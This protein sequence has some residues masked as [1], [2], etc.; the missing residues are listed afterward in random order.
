MK[1]TSSLF[2]S[3]RV[4]NRTSKKRPDEP[5]KQPCQWEGC[6]KAGTHKAPM[7]RN[8]EGQYLWMCIDHVRDY[9]KNFN[10]F[11][12]LDDD[13]IAKFQKDAITGARP[14]W[15]MGTN[16]TSRHPP[17]NERDAN[18]EGA[19]RLYNRTNYAAAARAGRV[20]PSRARKLKVLEKKSF[21]DLNLPY[22]ATSEELKAR[23]KLLVKQNHPD[24]NGGDR[25]SE[26]RLREI[27][28]AYKILQKAGFC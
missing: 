1:P 17:L 19:Q 21:D 16:K 14:T 20:A 13:A 9:N 18:A 28:L 15:Q 27:I 26:E 6:E 12:G 10:Y 8:R 11:S 3:I 2:D 4:G 23:Y 25:S 5:I 24:A 22:T 7:G